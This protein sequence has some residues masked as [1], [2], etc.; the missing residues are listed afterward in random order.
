MGFGGLHA[1]PAEYPL[2]GGPIGGPVG[3][4]G[5]FGY[6]WDYPEL[7]L[8]GHRY[9]NPNDGRFLTRDPIGYKGGINLYGFAGNNPVNESDP[10]GF[11]PDSSEEFFNDWNNFTLSGALQATGKSLRSNF[12]LRLAV[13]AAKEIYSIYDHANEYV[14]GQAQDVAQGNYR[15]Q[16]VP[17]GAIV[18]PGPSIF[19]KDKAGNNNVTEWRRSISRANIG[20][21]RAKFLGN[22][23]VKVEPG[24]W[25]SA[26]GLRQFRV[27]PQDYFGLHPIGKPSVPN[28]PH[29]HFEFLRPAAKVFRV[30]KNVHVPIVP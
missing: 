30:I 12:N 10:S 2:D 17:G 3:F 25:R 11:D 16:L 29:A 6:Y 20:A 5:Q 26:D 4:G 27:K 14:M 13:D 9:Y 21:E 22:N 28:I 15:E 23:Y 7:L 18:V 24:K 1:Y 19:A 8:L